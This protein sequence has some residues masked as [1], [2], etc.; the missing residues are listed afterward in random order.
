MI[1]IIAGPLKIMDGIILIN[2]EKGITSFGVVSA[3]RKI[4]NTK[5]VGHCGTLDPNA[6]G[7]L[8]VLIGAGTKAS[9]FLVEHN[10]EYVAVLKLGIKTDTADGDGRV[11]QT[12]EFKLEIANQEL[13]VSKIRE[14]IGK[15]TQVPPMYS[16]IKINGRKLYEYAREG[17]E[18]PRDGREIEIYSLD[19]EKIDYEQNEITFKVACSK[20]TYIRT[21]CETI[22]E[23]LG[24]IGYMKKLKRTKVDKFC[25]ENSIKLSELEKKI[26]K[27]K[28][29]IS[30]ENVFEEFEKINLSDRKLTLFLN[31]VN[32]TQDLNDGLYRIYS[33]SR[34]IGLG[35]CKGNLLKREIVIER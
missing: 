23:K 21:L 29:I 24:T 6:T 14:V 4:Y 19:I 33:D 9:K 11:L 22:S 32:L 7:V 30:L 17:K 13:Y 18:I 8:P 3:I 1:I 20:G 10:K 15:Q 16:A 2:K 26:D 25:I 34:F 5:K 12:D 31:G 28:Y 35:T 27:T